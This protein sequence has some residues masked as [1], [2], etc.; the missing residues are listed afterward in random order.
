MPA[1]F[2]FFVLAL[3]IADSANGQAVGSPDRTETSSSEPEHHTGFGAKNKHRRHH[4]PGTHPG[5][6]AGPT[7]RISIERGDT[8]L[9][10]ECNAS[11]ANC[12]E[13]LDRVWTSVRP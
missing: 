9:R 3:V 6:R 10:F 11:M 13:A 4:P 1:A 8:K 7:L 5:D 2:I 12:L